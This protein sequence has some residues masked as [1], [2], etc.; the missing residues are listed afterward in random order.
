MKI[1][2]PV[3]VDSSGVSPN[4]AMVESAID[5]SGMNCASCVAHVEKA[6]RQVNS[7]T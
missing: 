1:D 6:A 2:L 5:V 3:L 4:N 7:G